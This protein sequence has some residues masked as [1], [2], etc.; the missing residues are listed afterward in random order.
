MSIWG[1]I[2]HFPFYP[3]SLKV[4]VQ[5]K[6][7]GGLSGL[8]LF[9]GDED[10]LFWIHQHG[11][12]STFMIKINERTMITVVPSGWTERSVFTWPRRW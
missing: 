11:K 7:D 10:A 1:S 2:H 5:L 4:W 3:K 8:F 9:E 6:S 12:I